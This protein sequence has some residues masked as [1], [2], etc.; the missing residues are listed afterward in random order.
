[1]NFY[2]EVGTKTLSPYPNL[3]S[4]AVLKYHD[5]N[6]LGERKE[7][8]WLTGSSPSSRETNAGT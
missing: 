6:N 8:I 5:Q 7:F 4:I 1:M 2:L 3:L